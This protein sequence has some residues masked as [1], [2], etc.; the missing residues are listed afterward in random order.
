MLEFEKDEI[1][2]KYSEEI[3]TAGRLFRELYDKYNRMESKKHFY[4]EI[5]DLT[6]IEINTI[7]VIGQDEEPKKM[8]QLAGIL[9]VTSGTPTVTIDRLIG[10]GYVERIRDEVDRRQVFVQ[11]SQK[12]KE[13]FSAVLKLKDRITENIFGVLGPDE[14]KEAVRI[15]EI[16]NNRMDYFL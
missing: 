3:Y 5:Q 4:K 12:G 14:V 1:E 10:K 16:L 2:K 9:G 11:L 6:V 8:S 15:L 7:L 13:A